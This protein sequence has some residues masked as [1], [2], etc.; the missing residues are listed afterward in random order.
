MSVVDSSGAGMSATGHLT[1]STLPL[2]LSFQTSA[3]GLWTGKP[4]PFGKYQIEASRKGFQTA[5]AEL[6]VRSELPQ[7]L[8][9]TLRLA[10]TGTVVQIDSPAAEIDTVRT[11]SSFVVATELIENRPQNIPGRDLLDLVQRQPGWLLEANGVLHPR[12][13]EYDTQIVIDGMPLL[14]NRSPVYAPPIEVEGVQSVQT[15]T[16]GYP[17]EYGRKVGGIVEVTTARPSAPGF[18]GFASIQRGS[19]D[20]TSGSLGA[21]YLRGTTYVSARGFG[22]GT[23]RFLDPTTIENLSNHGTLGGAAVTAEHDLTQSQRIRVSLQR[24]QSRF[25]VP[26]E[27]LQQEAGQRQDRSNTETLG[28]VH[29]SYVLSPRLLANFRGMFR[30]LSAGLWSNPLA[31]PIAA[32]QQRQLRDSYLQANLS[33]QWHAHQFK[34]GVEG[35]LASVAERFSYLIPQS[36]RGRFDDDTPASFFFRDR[37]QNREVGV[38]AQDQFQYGPWTFSLGARFDRYRLVVTESAVSPR[39]GVAWHKAEWGFAI[40]ASY[41]RLFNTPAVENL[42]LSSSDAVRT[43]DRESL[44]LPVRPARGHQWEVGFSKTLGSRIRWSGAWF[45]RRWRNF[46]DDDLLMNTGVSFPVAFDRA[47]IRGFDSKLEIPHWGRVSGYLSYSYLIGKAQFP[48][49]GGLFLEEESADL[50]ESRVSFPITQDQ[51]HTA[52][53]RVRVD[54]TSRLWAALGGTYGSGLPVEFEEKVDREELEEQYGP[55]VLER[56]NFD[57]GRVRPS[58]SLDSSVGVELHQSEPVTARLQFDVRNWTDRLNVINFAGL[59]SGTAI[60]PPRM[61]SLRLICNF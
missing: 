32:E 9:L 6:E 17:A 54:L 36:A 5:M 18:R 15:L 38:Y 37:R 28:Q 31:F 3:E 39:L 58:F 53:A 55:R 34:V 11:G 61:F 13:A 4:L 23:D 50:L 12:G 10:P 19:F 24:R 60:A 52:T 26:N 49:A 56:V 22:A 8:K 21:S 20:S 48:V 14:D 2:R 59:F 47:R 57:R 51:R 35:N 27:L 45:D 41:D 44:F 33:G 40:R 30:D 46:A 29:Y 16:S 42:L 43:I 1:G 7:E 25:L